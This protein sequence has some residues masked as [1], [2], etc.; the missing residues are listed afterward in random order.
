[1]TPQ[2]LLAVAAGGALGSVGRYLLMS[3]I[4][5]GAF[6]LGTLAVNVIGSFVMGVFAEL[7]ALTF[8]PSPEVRALVAVGLL[9]GLTTFSTFSLDVVSLLQKGDWL[10]AGLYVAA[11]VCLSVGALFAGLLLTRQVIA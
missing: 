3:L 10:S 1:M 7:S 8:S 4:G 11:S 6:P 2:L 5:A 9:G